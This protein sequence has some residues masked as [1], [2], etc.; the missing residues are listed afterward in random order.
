M[1]FVAYDEVGL[2]QFLD[3]PLTTIE[4]PLGEMGRQAVLI[5][6]ALAAGDVAVSTVVVETPPRVIARASTVPPPHHS[7][8]NVES[9]D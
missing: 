5:A 7:A 2:A 1:S 4:M 3:P 6:R 8:E 9:A